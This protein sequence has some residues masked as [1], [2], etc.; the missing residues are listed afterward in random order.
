ME[1]REAEEDVEKAGCGRK[2]EGWLEKDICTWPFK[3]ECCRKQDCCRVKVNLATLTHWGYYQIL[4]NCVSISLS[5][6]SP[7]FSQAISNN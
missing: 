6:T 3:V 2:C 1:E 5:E 4:K 7:V